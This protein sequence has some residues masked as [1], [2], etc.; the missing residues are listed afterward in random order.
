[1]Y[2]NGEKREE[3]KIINAKDANML[4]RIRRKSKKHY[5]FLGHI[6]NILLESRA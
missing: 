1:M 4:G 2:K 3:D 6:M 5:G